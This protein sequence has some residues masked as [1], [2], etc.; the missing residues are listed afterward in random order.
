M[1]IILLQLN[2]LGQI[3]EMAVDLH[4]DK[5]ALSGFLQYLYMFALPSLYYR[6][7]QL[8]LRPLR[9]CHNLIHHLVYALLFNFPATF[10][11]VGNPDSRIEQTEIVIGR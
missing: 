7:Q 10:W 5:T 9:Q 8:N 1:L 4:P 3:I 6:C 2:L 11:T